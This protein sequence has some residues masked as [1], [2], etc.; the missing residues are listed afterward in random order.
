MPY[1]GYE[2][3]IVKVELKV[4]VINAYTVHSLL[5]PGVMQE[6][7]QVHHHP[8]EWRGEHADALCA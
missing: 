8:E 6:L 1:Q 4:R 2:K 5:S 3:G 7:Q